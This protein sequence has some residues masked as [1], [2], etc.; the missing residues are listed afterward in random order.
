[1]KKNEEIKIKARDLRS[2][3]LSVGD[4]SKKL[5]VSYGSVGNWVRDIILDEEQKKNISNI[6]QKEVQ[7]VFDLPLEIFDKMIED[8]LSQKMIADKLGV[9]LGIMS[10]VFKSKGLSGRTPKGQRPVFGLSDCKICGV[11]RKTWRG[12][13]CPTCVSKIRRLKTKIRAVKELGGKCK[14][15]SWEPTSREVA[16]MEFHHKGGDK[17][18]FEIGKKMNHKW[19]TLLPEIRKCKLLC[20]RCH[21]IEH[22][23]VDPLFDFIFD[24]DDKMR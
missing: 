5:S 23:R 12:G 17:K 8:G 9:S 21:R 14:S 7:R 24:Q 16:A 18:E 13:T 4:I 19:E 20:S 3:G 11:P 6:R 1:M 22:S 2:L 10:R 15:C